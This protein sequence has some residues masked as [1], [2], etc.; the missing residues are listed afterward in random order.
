MQTVRIPFVGSYNQRGLAGSADL[1]ANLD[2][3][4]LNCTFD[5]VR[6][7][8]TDKLTLYVQR[9]PGWSTDS[10]V[11]AGSAS[12]GCIHPQS[13]NATLSAFGETNSVIYYGQS[14]VGTITGRALQDR[15]STRLNSSHIQK[16]RMPSSA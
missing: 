6:N 9:R 2:Q 3:R 16:S 5:V 8:I 13:F 14:S 7:P 4:Y 15:K 10:L 12:T 11:A 1:T